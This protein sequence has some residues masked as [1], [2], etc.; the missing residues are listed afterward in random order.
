VRLAGAR[1]LS[2]IDRCLNCTEALPEERGH[3]LIERYVA[4]FLLAYL[5]GDERYA[6]F[7]TSEGAPEA[8]VV[9]PEMAIAP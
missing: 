7:L 3:V 4:S 9:T 5:A 2:F 8:T 6:R 1:H